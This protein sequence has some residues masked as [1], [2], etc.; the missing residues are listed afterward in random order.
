MSEEKQKHIESLARYTE[1][2]KLAEE[3]FSIWMKENCPEDKEIRDGFTDAIS[4]IVG[5]RAS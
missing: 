3:K 2:Y 4:D 5:V 1:G